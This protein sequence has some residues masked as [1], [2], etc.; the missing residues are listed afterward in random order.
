MMLRPKEIYYL[1]W[2]QNV[3]SMV[4][5]HVVAQILSFCVV[6]NLAL[7]CHLKCRNLLGKRESQVTENARVLMGQTRQLDVNAQTLLTFHRRGGNH[8]VLD[9]LIICNNLGDVL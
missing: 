5:D 7:Y 1:V 3:S 9:A 2:D 8:G 6:Y 4:V